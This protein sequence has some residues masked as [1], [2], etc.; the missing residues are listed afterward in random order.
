MGVMARVFSQLVPPARRVVA[1]AAC[2]VLITATAACTN[3]SNQASPEPA[4]PS[5]SSSVGSGATLEAKPVPL[6]IRVT[7]VSGKL[8]KSQRGSLERRVGKAVSGYFDAAWLGGQYPRTSF[9]GSF[10]T[11]SRGAARQAYAQRG[12]T[13]NAQLGGSTESVAPK[14]KKVWLSVLAP[15]KVAAGVTAR[16][17]L[18]FVADRGEAAAQ[19]VR[20]TGELLLTHKKAG[21]WQVFGYDVQRS[22]KAAGK[23]PN[24]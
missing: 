8:N 6:S 19:K 9:T 17:L 7:R 13:T 23:E 20:V 16:F 24:R 11:F 22:A 21:G 15:N 18:V 1:G 2:V 4:T 3:D 12:L 5:E 14:Q 10:P